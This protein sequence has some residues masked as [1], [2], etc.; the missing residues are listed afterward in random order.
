L[1]LLSAR[2]KVDELQQITEFTRTVIAAQNDDR[3]SFDRLEIWANDPAF[4]LKAEAASAWAE[5]RDE[6]APLFYATGFTIPWS[7]GTDPSKLTLPDLTREYGRA[8]VALR[9]ALIEYIWK[10]EDIRK[11][12][13]MAFLADVVRQDTS[14][15][16]VEYA[17]RF[18]S[19][20][21]G[22]KLKPLAVQKLLQIWEQQ[23]DTIE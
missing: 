17:G 6:H 7:E 20:A 3:R 12:D 18:L 4:P 2:A 21:L 22:A 13:R 5:I 16:A 11:V 9:P 10:R 1:A 23:K 15:K 8:P 19:E 14:L